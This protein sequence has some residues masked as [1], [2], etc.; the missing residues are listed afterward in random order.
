MEGEHKAAVRTK[1][2]Y[3]R[4]HEQNFPELLVKK[5]EIRISERQVFKS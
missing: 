1:V 5:K 4:N 3:P 2:V